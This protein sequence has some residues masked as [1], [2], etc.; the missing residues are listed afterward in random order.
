MDWEQIKDIGSFAGLI[1][2]VWLLVRDLLIGAL[3]AWR[4]PRLRI[5]D[6]SVR[7]L[8]I[9]PVGVRQFW[10]LEIE[11][12]GTK[13]AEHCEAIL[14]IVRHPSDVTLS[15]KK[16]YLHWVDTPYEDR[17]SS[18]TPV[19]IAAHHRLDVVFSAPELPGV[20]V[21]SGHALATGLVITD[22]YFLPP[23]EY[24]VQVRIFCRNGKGLKKTFTLHSPRPKHDIT[25]GK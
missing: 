1:A 12:T 5:I 11:N 3:R 21:A 10:H 23:G 9:N 22:H 7:D 13:P 25:V 14:T 6:S 24:T 19:N 16:F 17:V 18:M 15:Q 8:E 20:R 2:L 4:R